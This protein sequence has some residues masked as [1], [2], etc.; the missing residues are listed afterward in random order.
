MMRATRSQDYSVITDIQ[1][2]TE[3]LH[4][5]VPTVE[6]DTQQ[7]RLAGRRAGPQSCQRRHYGDGSCPGDL[8]RSRDLLHPE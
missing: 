1:Q 8:R 2:E 6:G 7:Q 3:P 5:I 4:V